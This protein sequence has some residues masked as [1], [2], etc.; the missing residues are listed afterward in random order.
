MEVISLYAIAWLMFGFSDKN[1]NNM[2]KLPAEINNA[3]RMTFNV[4]GS[5][6]IIKESIIVITTLSLSIG[7]TC[8]TF[9]FCSALK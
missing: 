2:I 1:Y 8:D 6:N 4:T 9:P 7:A 5:F 3:P